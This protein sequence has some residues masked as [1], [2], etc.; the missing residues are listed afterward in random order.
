MFPI[1]LVVLE[2]EAL[3]E[4]PQDINTLHEMFLLSS[5]LLFLIHNCYCDQYI[6]GPG[7]GSDGHSELLTLDTDLTLTPLSGQYPGHGTVYGC[8]GGVHHDSVLVCGGA[9][10]ESH[11]SRDC[12]SYDLKKQSWNNFT[13]LK[14]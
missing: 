5:L 14:S 12:Y 3:I 4:K 8:A 7:D 2:S 10:H 11:Y 6:L 1:I 13:S 9:D